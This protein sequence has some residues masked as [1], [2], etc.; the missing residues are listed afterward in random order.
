MAEIAGRARGK[1]AV[2]SSANKAVA[3][4]APATPAAATQSAAAA[5]HQSVNTNDI[6]QNHHSTA[7]KSMSPKPHSQRDEAPK[8][9]HVPRDHQ[10]T[11]TSS[12]GSRDDDKNRDIQLTPIAATTPRSH[13]MTGTE[14]SALNSTLV[15]TPSSESGQTHTPYQESGQTHTPYQESGQTHTPYQK[16]GQTHTPYQETLTVNAP[17]YRSSSPMAP[18]TIMPFSTVPG[19]ADNVATVAA[20]AAAATSATSTILPFASSHTHDHLGGAAAGAASTATTT[21]SINVPIHAT[22]Q[23]HGSDICRVGSASSNGSGSGGMRRPNSLTMIFDEL[24]DAELPSP[25]SPSLISPRQPQEVGEG[26][27][28]RLYQV[29]GMRSHSEES[30]PEW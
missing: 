23:P 29:D 28:G 11:S 10:Q 17:S 24:V 22:D 26:Q 19:G 8:G 12:N 15:E 3:A 9:F 4:T 25:M 21:K 2:A 7:S 5:A 20:A 1:T 14:T 6:F 30:C 16:S 13:T 27:Q 18:V